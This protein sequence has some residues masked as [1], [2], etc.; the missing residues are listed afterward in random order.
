MDREKIIKVSRDFIQEIKKYNSK[1]VDLSGIQNILDCIHIDEGWHWGLRLAEDKG[2]GDKSWFYCYYGDTDTYC[3]EYGKPLNSEDG[4]DSFWKYYDFK[5]V[6]EIFEH[7]NVEKSDMGVWQAYLLSNATFILPTY[8]HG[9]Y[10]KRKFILCKE[11]THHVSWLFNK[12]S[13]PD[14][15]E[16]VGPDIYY[17]GTSATI[18][19]CFWSDFQGLFRETVKMSIVDGRVIFGDEYNKTILYKYSCKLKF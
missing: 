11:D 15:N 3:R 17:D 18:S 16:D 8:W 5:E 2:Y 12:P 4:M 9:G 1:T 7:L 14:L 19:C 6:F 13:I 10:Q